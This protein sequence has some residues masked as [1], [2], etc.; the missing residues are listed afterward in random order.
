[1][2]RSVRWSVAFSLLTLLTLLSGCASERAP[3]NRVQ[4]EALQKS[5]FVGASLTDD[6]DDPQ[7][8]YRPTVADV[9]YGASQ[10][11]LFTASYAQTTARVRWEITEEKL[12]ARLAYE[13]IAGSTGNGIDETKTGQIA[14]AFKIEKHFDVR[15]DYNPQTGENLNII[16][17]NDTDRPWYER[18]FMRVDWSQNLITTAYDLDTLA[19]L[20]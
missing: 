17:E 20:K 16:V 9:D 3:I 5:F 13:R 8:Y 2:T 1:M 4:P 12:I 11:G 7:F 15:R 19:S 10:S 6:A 18:E 14:A